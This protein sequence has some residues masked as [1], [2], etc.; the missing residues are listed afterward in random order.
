MRQ[1]PQFKF[2][3]IGNGRTARHIS[4]YLQSM[5]HLISSWHYR[6][7]SI[8]ELKLMS[9]NVDRILLLIRDS[10]I[11]S[12]LEV[13]PYLKTLST[14]H[15]SGALHVDGIS[16]VHP[17]IS[18]SLDLFPLTFYE[19]IPFAYFD[20]KISFVDIFPGALNP[21]FYIPLE[22]KGLYHGL[23][24]ASGN[25]TVHLWQLVAS[26][27]Q[28]NFSLDQKVLIPFLKSLNLNLELNWKEALTGPIAR[29]DEKTLATN[30]YAL[31]L[32]P[33]IEIFEAHVKV[34]WPEFAIKHFTKLN[35]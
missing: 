7:Q 23:C 29:R 8:S 28:H 19:T 11:E 34:A 1:V 20:P 17:L 30:Y 3:V 13:N 35:K 6:S 33:L 31:Q 26:Q 15:F 25:L 14:I 12:F 5:G 10:Q 21:N 27:F 24:V 2:L 4:Y 18:F 16:N 32:T 9:Q 22:T